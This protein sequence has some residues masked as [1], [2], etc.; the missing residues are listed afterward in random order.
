MRQNIL[1]VAVTL[2]TISSGSALASDPAN[3]ICP[4]LGRAELLTHGVTKDTAFSDSDWAWGETPKE[5]PQAKVIS[6][7]CTI[8]MKSKVG[9]SSIVLAV[10]RFDGMV[11]EA[12]V[13]TWIKAI[14]GKKDEDEDVKVTEF[15]DVVC[16]TGS[17]ELPT[18]LDEGTENINELYVACDTQVGTRH[19]SLNFHFPEGQKGYLPSPEQAKA[20]LDSSVKRLK[21]GK[22]T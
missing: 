20:I 3:D 18:T 16:E 8:N 10:D 5:T 9:S 6:N 1:A 2:I 15:G 12:E 21:E 17:Y 13:G 4:F 14:A 7:L 22:R 11:T 19:V